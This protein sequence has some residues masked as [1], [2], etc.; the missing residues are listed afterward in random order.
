L[1]NAPITAVWD[2]ITDS[3]IVEK[4]S[5]SPCLIT[6]KV[7]ERFFLWGGDVWGKNI[8]VMSPM[9]GQG[10][11]VQE[12]YEKDWE[13]PSLVVFKLAHG[14]GFTELIVEHKGYPKGEE[15]SLFEAWDEYYLKPLKRFLEQK[16]LK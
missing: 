12:W 3:S 13:N 7:G 4:W 6:D 14:D 11:I 2:A 10:K 5:A 16:T 9:N 15:D 1:I 8:E